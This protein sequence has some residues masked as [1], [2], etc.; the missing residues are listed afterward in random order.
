MYRLSIIKQGEKNQG[1]SSKEMK[2]QK[3]I[4]DNIMEDGL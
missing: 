4:F 2:S 3:D 1:Y